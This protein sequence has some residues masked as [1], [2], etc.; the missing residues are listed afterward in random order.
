LFRF[1]C[2]GTVYRVK[3]PVRVVE[4]VRILTERGHNVFRL[5]WYGRLGMGG[6]EARSADYEQAAEWV[7]RQGLDD[8]VTFHGPRGD[9]ER[10]YPEADALVHASLQEGI[11]NA[12]V[13]GMACGLPVVVSRV[14]DLPLIVET[15]KNGFVCDE[16]SPVAI[17]DAMQRLLE[18][19][20]AER[21]A[22]GTRSR[23]LAMRWFGMDR[24]VSEFEALYRSLLSRP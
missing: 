22:M 12:V 16:T 18:T 15:A 23:E 8:R 6:P 5:D 24:F 3:N 7:S 2:V 21:A 14:S 1:V 20:P 17:A 13:E 19:P 11:P 9:I 10:V 4:A